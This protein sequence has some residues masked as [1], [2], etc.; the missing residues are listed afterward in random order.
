M[1]QRKKII[2]SVLGLSA[3][4]FSGCSIKEDS[5][6]PSDSAATSSSSSTI[7]MNKTDEEISLE[8]IIQ[9][10]QKEY[11]KTDIT[12][13]DYD[14]SFN[15]WYFKVEGINDTTEF[16]LRINPLTGEVSH[17][18]EKKLDKSESTTAYRES[19]KLDLL[20]LAPLEEIRQSAVK[21]IESG[22]ATD[23]ELEKELNRTYWKVTIEDGKKEH[24]VKIDAK[25]K[26]ILEMDLDD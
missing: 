10:Y 7:E 13:I 18:K 9:I 17:K 6:S 25:T 8:E 11:P 19:K 3:L 14:S 5:S 15:V 21:A 16:E 1:K 23:L 12:S 26:E 2:F 22:E 4:L 24:E 20:E